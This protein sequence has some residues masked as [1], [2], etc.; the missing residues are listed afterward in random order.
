MTPPIP[1]RAST[2]ANSEQSSLRLVSSIDTAQAGQNRR[3]VVRHA[4]KRPS[5]MEIALLLC[6][7]RYA[8][9]D[10]NFPVG[11]HHWC[12]QAAVAS[13]GGPVY[14]RRHLPVSFQL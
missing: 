9:E 6:P 12:G 5:D 14:H 13:S 1:L 3:S 8:E 10:F 11:R 2:T 7:S 4:A